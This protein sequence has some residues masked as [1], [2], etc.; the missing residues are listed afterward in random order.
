MAAASPNYPA[1]AR[2]ASIA[3]QKPRWD[4]QLKRLLTVVAGP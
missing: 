1:H 2:A 4:Q 3:V